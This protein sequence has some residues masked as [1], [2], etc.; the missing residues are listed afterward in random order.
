MKGT[1]LSCVCFE[2]HS[3]SVCSDTWWIDTGSMIHI[4]NTMHGFLSIR[5][6][7][8][9]EHKVL[10]GNGIGSNVEAVGTFRIV[11]STNYVLDLEQT[12]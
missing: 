9:S 11:L 8:P 5:N 10:P 7:H 4:A 6:P 1:L 2:S 3:V 12:F